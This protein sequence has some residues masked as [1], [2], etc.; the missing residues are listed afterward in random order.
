LLRHSIACPIS[1]T[2]LARRNP[3]VRL[4]ILTVMPTFAAIDIGSNSVRLKIARL[5]GGTLK[6]VH[7]DREVT[8]LGAGVFSGGLLSPES[9]SETVRV[10]RRFH[11]ATQE[12]GTDSIKVVATAA[13]R[14]A[15]NSRAF[16]EWVR[17]TTGW[18]IEIISGLEEARLI[19][20][21]IVS[22]RRLGA[23]SVLMVDL[24]G[25]SCELTVSR[26]G[27]LLYTVSLPL[28]A[29][30][31]TGE[32]LQHDPPRKSELKRLKGFVAREITRVQ[33]RIKSAHVGTVIATSGT[34]AAL[35][36]AANNLTRPRTSRTA[37]YATREMIRRVVKQITHQTLEQRTKVPGIGPRRAEII[38]AGAVVYSELLERFHL[39]GFRYSPLGLRD[40]ILAQMA[41]EYDRSTRSGRAIES[42]RWDSI[43]RAVEHYRVDL[44]HAL[45]VRE[46][47][48]LLFSSLKSVHQLPAEYR[49][50]L[51]AAAM[52][53][54]VGDYVNRNGHHRHTYYIIANSE[55]LGYTPQQRQIIGSI[56]RYL[57]KSR[58]TPGDGPVNGLTAEE[59]ENITKASIL[60]R[61]ARALHMGRIHSVE[62]FSV[63]SRSGKVAMKLIARGKASVDLEVWAIEK[64]R[65]Y[66]REVFGRELSV[67]A[68]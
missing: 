37:T 62:R 61:I 2:G 54:E 63:S 45:L 65:L 22:T 17:S 16:L 51:S 39:P 35:A 42:E 68:A 32:F 21:G 40:G 33:D 48:L 23:G 9:M 18:T 14:D 38:C 1:L 8:R 53:Y 4:L 55:I 30:R 49:E 58:P 31:L 43:K 66:F 52:L 47:A 13:L 56:A 41:A 34:A 36:G 6:E 50:W 59:Q 25:G 19:H 26:S 57:G 24:G 15:R 20:L 5:Q 28:G 7:E 12:C 46:S 44:N 3:V 64:D 10:L 60:L 29:V 67:A 27:K 11:R